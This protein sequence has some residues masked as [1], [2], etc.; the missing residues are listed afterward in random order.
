MG[1]VNPVFLLPSALEAGAEALAGGLAGSITLG[2]GQ[3]CTNPGVVVGQRGGALD[4]FAEALRRRIAD[5]PAAAMLYPA[6]GDGYRHGVEA[7]RSSGGVEVLAES[8]AAA[9]A[10]RAQGRPILFA[11]PAERFVAE[12]RLQEEVFGPSSLLVTA[13]SAE[14]LEAV[15]R[16]LEGQLTASIHGSEEELLRHRGL[17]RILERKVGRLIFN[18]FPTGVEV[19]HAMHHGGPYPATTDARTTSVGTAAISRFARPVAY[20][21]F[22][23]AALPP[24][25]Q[26]GNP[27][28]VW[29]MVDGEWGTA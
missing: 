11:T 13:G 23:D 27:R 3:F 22:P 25:L 2:V 21:D 16:S 9:D 1:S 7:L 12:P 17:V 28:G 10:G 14:E 29:R 15:A 6:I 18:G 24:E 26:D 4:R 8:S 5:A 19:G 20:Q